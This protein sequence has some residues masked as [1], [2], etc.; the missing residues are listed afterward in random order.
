[1]DGKGDRISCKRFAKGTKVIGNLEEEVE[2]WY[3]R[4]QESVPCRLRRVTGLENRFL[5]LWSHVVNKGC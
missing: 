4:Y 2:F 3:I 1:M 5:H